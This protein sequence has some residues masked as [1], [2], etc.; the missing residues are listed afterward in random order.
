MYNTIVLNSYGEIVEEYN[1]SMKDIKEI[2]KRFK[3]SHER[4]IE[5][6]TATFELSDNLSSNL[7]MMLH[8]DKTCT[9]HDVINSHDYNGIRYTK[10]EIGSMNEAIGKYGNPNRYKKKNVKINKVNIQGLINKHGRIKVVVIEEDFMEL[11]NMECH[12]D[13]EF[14]EVV[15]Q[16][17]D[18]AYDRISIT[19]SRGGLL[20][21]NLFIR[22][23]LVEA[24]AYREISCAFDSLVWSHGLQAYNSGSAEKNVQKMMN[25]NSMEVCC[26]HESQYIGPIGVFLKGEAQC[27]SNTDLCSKI[28]E[29][30][31]RVFKNDEHVIDD[32]N[33]IDLN[34]HSHMEAIIANFEIVGVWI[35]ENEL[36]YGERDISKI[37]EITKLNIDDVKIVKEH[38]EEEDDFIIF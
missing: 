10:H 35:K 11:E 22:E 34:I 25:N 32:I 26:A 31:K 28:N 3:Y 27:V 18:R 16:Y 9:I 2:S 20:V 6:N 24:S 15:E 8:E 17:K 29:E 21:V 7:Y 33:K 13:K 37:L 23:Q 1:M 5:G 30:G 36:I 12:T 19:K 38:K 14:Y 4:R